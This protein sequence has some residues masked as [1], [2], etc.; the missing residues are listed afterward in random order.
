MATIVGFGVLHVGQP[1]ERIGPRWI[2]RDLPAFTSI[3]TFQTEVEPIKATEKLERDDSGAI[4]V[5]W[6]RVTAEMALDVAASA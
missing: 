6:S 4:S 3:E 2:G 1:P 5:P